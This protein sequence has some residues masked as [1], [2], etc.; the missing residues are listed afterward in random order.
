VFCKY[1]AGKEKGHIHIKS[2][3]PLIVNRK[4][5]SHKDVPALL[6]D[7]D[8]SQNRAANQKLRKPIHCP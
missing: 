3:C 1:V 8:L 5:T 7:F 2:L 6:Q 4:S